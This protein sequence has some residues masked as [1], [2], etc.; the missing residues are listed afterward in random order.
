M[1][2]LKII[3]VTNKEGMDTLCKKK[4]FVELIQRKWVVKGR[5]IHEEAGGIYVIVCDLPKCKDSRFIA[6]EFIAIIKLLKYYEYV[7]MCKYAHKHVIHIPDE[8]ANEVK[9]YLA[10]KCTVTVHGDMY[11]KIEFGVDNESE[12]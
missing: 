7:S 9:P 4:I 5:M 6:E 12:D 10:M 2:K 1:G 8:L 3:L 11:K